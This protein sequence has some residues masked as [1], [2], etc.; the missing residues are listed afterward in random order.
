MFKKTLLALAITS[1]TSIASAAVIDSGSTTGIPGATPANTIQTVSAEGAVGST[2][3]RALP[4]TFTVGDAKLASYATLDKLVVDIKGATLAP[5]TEAKITF[6]DTADT[7]VSIAPNITFPTTTRVEFDLTYTDDGTAGVDTGAKFV[8]DGLDL[9]FDSL[10]PGAKVEYTISA[11]SSVGGS[12]IE[13]ESATITQVVNQITSKATTELDAV[14][15]VETERLLFTGSSKADQGTITVLSPATDLLT[16]TDFANAVYTL[17]GDF[18]F[19]DVDGDGKIDSGFTLDG[20]VADDLQ[21]A[22]VKVPA[23]TAGIFNLATD[24]KVII[25]DQKFN[26][27]VSVDYKTAAAKSATY[28]KENIEAG[29]WTL[30]GYSGVISFLPFGNGESQLIT[31]TNSGALEGEITGELIV[32]GEVKTIALGMAKAKAV[33]NVGKLVKKYAADN[34]IVGN[35]AVKIIVNAPADNITVEGIYFLNGDRV[36]VPTTPK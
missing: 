14:V 10:E 23:G 25:K 35:Y 36:L 11:L 5:S 26:A 20:V 9:T 8:I 31:V 15:D 22:V 34:A 21:S 27:D 17:K 18:S 4:V 24:G 13:T 32:G 3:A 29:E 28:T 1:F 33:T 19:M 7:A 6:T 16:A 30:N 2:S 12:V